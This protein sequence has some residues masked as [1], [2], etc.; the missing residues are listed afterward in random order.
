MNELSKIVNTN[1]LHKL[2]QQLAPAP[3]VANASNQMLNS[4]DTSVFAWLDSWCEKYAPEVRFREWQK[5]GRFSVITCLHNPD[6]LGK[7]YI[8]QSSSGGISARCHSG[9][10]TWGWAQYRQAKESQH[11]PITPSFEHSQHS[12]PSAWGTPVPLSYTV[13]AELP[14]LD[15]ALI[16][17]V[18]LPYCKDVAFR[19]QAPIEYVLTALITSFS[20]MLGNK[21][22]VH[23]KQNDTWRCAPVLWGIVVGE[24][25][26]AKT[27]VIMEATKFVAFL[28]EKMGSRYETEKK[29][30]SSQIE[31][32]KRQITSLK[33]SKSAASLQKIDALENQ[34]SGL[35]D[36]EPVENRIV[37]KDVTIEKLQELLSSNPQGLYFLAD[38]LVNL[39]ITMYKSG[40][41]NDRGFFLE[42]WNGVNPYV[43]DRIGRGTVK[44]PKVCVGILG[45]IQPDVLEKNIQKFVELRGSDGFFARFQIVIYPPAQGEWKLIDK[46]PDYDAEDAVRN[47]INFLHQWIPQNDPNFHSYSSYKLGEPGINFDSNAQ[48]LFNTWLAEI[49]NKKLENKAMREHL[50]KYN[51]LCAKLALVFHTSKH[52]L[53]GA[54]PPLIDEIEVARAIAWCEFLEPHAEKMYGLAH[55]AVPADVQAAIAILDKIAE[56]KFTRCN[57]VNELLRKNWSKCTNQTVVED[58]LDR[59]QNNGWI[60]LT[61]QP[62]TAAGGRPTDV[63]TLHPKIDSLLSTRTNYVLTKPT[64]KNYPWLDKLKSILSNENESPILVDFQSLAQ[65]QNDHDL[66]DEDLIASQ[67]HFDFI[68]VLMATTEIGSENLLI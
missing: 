18:L 60:K 40:H 21:I 49:M 43:V 51:S 30:H 10:C 27:P 19:M 53:K 45:T 61:K 7:A 66:V 52:A 56:K 16:P 25:G 48:L 34:I 47:I 44:I 33:R 63:I 5:D 8:T 1:Q 28:D 17:E 26:T 24:P 68:K 14:V 35:K 38:E 65:L 64:P 12:E 54:I 67:N 31:A 37:V 39:F 59:L 46:T 4:S 20:A 41:E 55:P 50:A 13:G 22:L 36:S 23:P 29:L 62:V 58:A 3:I 2:S 11:R 32:L 42:A 9:S 6:H 15:A 57:T